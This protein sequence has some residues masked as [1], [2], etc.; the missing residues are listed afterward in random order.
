MKRRR[1][2]GIQSVSQVLAESLA[3]P[4]EDIP[5]LPQVVI[6]A[7][8]SLVAKAEPKTESQQAFDTAARKLLEYDRKRAL[9]KYPELVHLPE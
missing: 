2:A 4:R 9:E 6:P 8:V 7:S 3:Q 1:E 5:P